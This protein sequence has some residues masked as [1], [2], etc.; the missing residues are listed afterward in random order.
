[1]Y[2]KSENCPSL[3]KPTLKEPFWIEHTV[4]LTKGAF[5]QFFTDCQNILLM[6]KAVK[7]F[8]Q[9]NLPKSI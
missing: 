6:N 5:T 8:S 4:L 9:C 1:M 7:T 2:L 3:C